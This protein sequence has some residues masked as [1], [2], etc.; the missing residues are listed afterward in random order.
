M[1]MPPHYKKPE[2]MPDLDA[3]RLDEC[4]TLLKDKLENDWKTTL[5]SFTVSTRIVYEQLAEQNF[6]RL[7]LGHRK[8]T[9]MLQ[10]YIGI[11]RSK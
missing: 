5:Q 3:T 4:I 2:L 6:M 11:P 7:T 9:H 1:T 8:M 10:T